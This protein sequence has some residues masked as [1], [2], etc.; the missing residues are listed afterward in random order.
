MGLNSGGVATLAGQS[1]VAGTADGPTSSA[2]LDTLGLALKDGLLYAAGFDG[3]IRVLDKASKQ[4][5]TLPVAGLTDIFANR[6]GPE[7]QSVVLRRP[8][9]RCDCDRGP[10]T[11]RLKFTDQVQPRKRGWTVREARFEWI[12]GLVM[13]KDGEKIYAADPVNEAVRVID[14]LT[15]GDEHHPRLLGAP[16]GLA[17]DE[18]K[19][20]L[21]VSDATSGELGKSLWKMVRPH[22]SGGRKLQSPWGLALTGD[23]LLVEYGG[24]RIHSVDRL[25]EATIIAGTGEAGNGDGPAWR[26]SSRALRLAWDASTNTLYTTELR[27]TGSAPSTGK[28]I[29]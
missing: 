11:H 17:L 29:R 19:G 25:R 13:S 27:D 9:Y 14:L 1:G 8:V 24:N 20:I 15:E 16:V 5:S 12:Y 6:R 10:E 22:N 4:I 23:E 21:Y 2:L 7:L 3:L 18:A 26:R 28:P